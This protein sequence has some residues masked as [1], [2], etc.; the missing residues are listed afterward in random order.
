MKT[1]RS[2]QYLSWINLA[3]FLAIAIIYFAFYILIT[4]YLSWKMT[5]F[6]IEPFYI[7][8]FF[9]KNTD[10]GIVSMMKEP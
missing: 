5:E 8:S 3:T 4:K 6:T 2:T 7:K 9:Q 10:I 1:T